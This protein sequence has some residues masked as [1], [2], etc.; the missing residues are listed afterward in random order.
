MHFH[1]VADIIQPSIECYVA[2][3]PHTQ[4]QSAVR[5]H[6]S[7]NKTTRLMEIDTPCVFP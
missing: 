2:A 7:W 3:C 1:I 4:L 6:L 5:L